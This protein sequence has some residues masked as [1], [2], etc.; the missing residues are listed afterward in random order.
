MH[1]Y[2]DY[3]TQELTTGEQLLYMLVDFV[4]NFLESPR[5]EWR[6]ELSRKEFAQ[7]NGVWLNEHLLNIIH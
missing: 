4:Q 5:I 7:S 2:W 3:P 6:I 1:I